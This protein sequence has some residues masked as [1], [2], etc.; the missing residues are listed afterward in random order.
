MKEKRQRR[1]IKVFINISIFIL[2]S[3][4]ITLFFPLKTEFK[5]EFS[6]GKPWMHED[7]YAPFDFSINKSNEQITKE[8]DSLLSKR[9]AELYLEDYIFSLSYGLFIY[10][11]YGFTEPCFLLILVIIF[12]K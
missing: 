2:A 6:E 11:A 8:K 4:I 12:E 7:F 10:H 3:I 5:F 9:I 1:H